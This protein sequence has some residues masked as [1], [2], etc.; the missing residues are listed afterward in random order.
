MIMAHAIEETVVS[1][2]PRELQ[3]LARAILR[4][5]NVELFDDPRSE[6]EVAIAL[7]YLTLEADGGQGVFPDQS[8]V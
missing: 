5:R 7:G 8:R 3:P 6:V 4:A 1:L 2:Q